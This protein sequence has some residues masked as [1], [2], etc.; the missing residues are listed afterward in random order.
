MK[1]QTPTI[2]IHGTGI[3]NR[4]AELMAIAI[5]ERLR[6]VYPQVHIVVPPAFGWP[7]DRKRYGFLTTWE[8]TTKREGLRTIASLISSR[9]INPKRVDVVL[10][11]SGFAFSDQWGD[12]F[13]RSLVQK[14]NKPQRESQLLVLL[15]QALGPFEDQGVRTWAERLFQRATLV[16]ARDTKSYM[17]AQPIAQP[18]KL[19]QSPDFTIAVKP[20]AKHGIVFPQHFAALVPNMRMLDKSDNPEAYLTF[21]RTCVRLLSEKGIT[22]AFVIHD[23]KED[24]EVI[25]LLGEEYKGLPVFQDPDPRVLKWILGKAEFVIG[26]RFHA[27]VSTLSQG[28]PCIGAGWSHKYPELFADFACPH[29][30]VS[31]LADLDKLRQQITVLTTPEGRNS[32]SARIS[33]AASALKQ[34]VDEMWTTVVGKINEQLNR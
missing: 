12:F 4:G 2:E 13:A 14:M 18:G 28:V 32:E 26:S 8:A 17:Y 15:P 24:R 10:D 23:A 1:T 25:G 7:D 27:L 22:P 29:A 19:I 5:A 31:D 34:K 33:T 9:V 6:S 20:M 11:A 3:H 21:L 30:L 16:L